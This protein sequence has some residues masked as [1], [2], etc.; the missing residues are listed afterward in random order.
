MKT[1]ELKF[2]FE[3]DGPKCSREST[4][5][6]EELEQPKGWT[7]PTEDIVVFRKLVKG[8][9]YDST[10]IEFKDKHFCTLK[11]AQNWIIEQANALTFSKKDA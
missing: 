1:K 4:V 5:E 10:S 2:K 6:E 8:K 7:I 9:K 11:C 3:C